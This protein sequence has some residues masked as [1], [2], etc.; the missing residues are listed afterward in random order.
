MKII[1]IE[2]D[3][4]N[5]AILLLKPHFAAGAIFLYPNEPPKI[6]TPTGIAQSQTLLCLPGAL[7]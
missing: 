3:V 1:K 5:R 7:P 6:Y 4:N 2:V